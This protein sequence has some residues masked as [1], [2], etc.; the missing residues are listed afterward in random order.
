M[1]GGEMGVAFCL[2]LIKSKCDNTRTTNQQHRTWNQQNKPD[3]SLVPLL[4]DWL[5]DVL[6]V[7]LKQPE[8]DEDAIY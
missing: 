8:H 2:E 6:F 7:S 4:A 5:A 1:E 3:P